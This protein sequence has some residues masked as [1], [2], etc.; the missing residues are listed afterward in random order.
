MLTGRKVDRIPRR[1]GEGC[2]PAVR[3][4]GKGVDPGR[5]ADR[6]QAWSMMRLVKRRLA[7]G[8]VGNTGCWM[9]DQ[10]AVGRKGG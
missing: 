2:W 4:I 6:K 8:E 5:E 3:L 10:K 7:E 9:M 1:V